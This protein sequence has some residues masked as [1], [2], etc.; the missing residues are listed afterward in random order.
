MRRHNEL[1]LDLPPASLPWTDIEVN[2]SFRTDRCAS[3]PE[4]KSVQRLIGGLPDRYPAVSI[5][6]LEV[7]V[8]RLVGVAGQIRRNALSWFKRIH[9]HEI[10]TF[11][12]G[13]WPQRIFWSRLE[14]EVNDHAWAR[15]F[16]VDHKKI[17]VSVG[18]IQNLTEQ[19]RAPLFFYC[20]S[21]GI[22]DGIRKS[23]PIRLVVHLTQNAYSRL[24]ERTSGLGLV[25]TNGPSWRNKLPFGP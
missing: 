16:A 24:Q 22:Y 13:R 4:V 7:V 21:P 9:K 11:D 2:V 3:R 20:P 1:V 15:G 10:L 25:V 18:S 23:E 8:G 19:D 5:L 17:S 12:L 14:G 6:D